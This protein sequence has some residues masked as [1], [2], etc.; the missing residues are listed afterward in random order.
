MSHDVSI[1]SLFKF[2]S[3][4]ESFHVSQRVHDFLFSKNVIFLAF[5]IIRA[6][7]AFAH[8]KM[9]NINNNHLIISS[10]PSPLSNK[11]QYK[12]NPSFSGSKPFSKINQLLEN[13]IEW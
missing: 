6:W 3:Y 8:G 13:K 11:R 10:H 5:A 12:Q 2:L 4:F 1:N 7:G 9:E